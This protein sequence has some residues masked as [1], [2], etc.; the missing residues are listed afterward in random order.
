MYSYHL[1]ESSRQQ[2]F[3]DGWKPRDIPFTGQPGPTALLADLG[4]DSKPVEYFEKF[5]TDELL[6]MLVVETN[7]YAEQCIAKVC[8]FSFVIFFEMYYTVHKTDFFYHTVKKHFFFYPSR[9]ARTSYHLTHG[10]GP[11]NQQR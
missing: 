7:R 3:S 10:P 8:V 5:L 9:S 6:E 11:G 1:D 2:W 4:P